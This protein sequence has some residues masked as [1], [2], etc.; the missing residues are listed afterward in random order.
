MKK[1]ILIYGLFLGALWSI[2]TFTTTSLSIE[3]ALNLLASVIC[4]YFATRAYRRLN[5]GFA[6]F[7][8]LLKLFVPLLVIAIISSKTVEYV[9]LRAMS[10]EKL[11]IVI[12]QRGQS[13]AAIMTIFP[14]GEA[15]R[16][17]LEQETTDRIRVEIL[18][19][20]TYAKDV[21]SSFM[22]SLLLCLIPAAIFKK[23]PITVTTEKPA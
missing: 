18:S 20:M 5:G 9:A 11:E 10:K 13:V 4:L 6:A 3:I 21:F 7:G 17:E 8:Q 12:R 2:H 16:L 23:N 22:V 14:I 15:E 1:I 19:P